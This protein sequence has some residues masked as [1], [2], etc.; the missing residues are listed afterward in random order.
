MLQTGTRVLDGTL[1]T[2]FQSWYPG[3]FNVANSNQAME[4]KAA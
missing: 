2:K 1:G 3:L 4:R